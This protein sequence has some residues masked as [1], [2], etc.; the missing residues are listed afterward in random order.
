M[1][2]EGIKVHLNHQLSVHQRGQIV[3]LPPTYPDD[4]DDL[5]DSRVDQVLVRFLHHYVKDVALHS[6][7][8]LRRLS[9]C[10]SS[11]MLWYKVET[12]F[13]ARVLISVI[14]DFVTSSLNLVQFEKDAI[15]MTV[16]SMLSKFVRTKS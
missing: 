1:V 12:A 2:G 16:L 4:D 14:W 5:R 7:R 11:T 8:L 13:C 10:S 9:D 6:L 15:T 3:N